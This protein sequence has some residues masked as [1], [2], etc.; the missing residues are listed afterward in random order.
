MGRPPVGGAL[1][2]T[3]PL[4]HA[5]SEHHLDGR[6]G[7]DHARNPPLSPPP[8]LLLPV[9]RAAVLTPHRAIEAD[10]RMSSSG[11]IGPPFERVVEFGKARVLESSNIRV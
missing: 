2:L 7:G 10:V 9:L 1:G 11:M 6:P 4:A 8:L 3:P 5:P